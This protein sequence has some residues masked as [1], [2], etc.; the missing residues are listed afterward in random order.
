MARYKSLFER[1]HEELDPHARV[2]N[3]RNRQR[4][5]RMIIHRFVQAVLMVL[6]VIALFGLGKGFLHWLITDSAS[7]Q[8]TEQEA[9]R[10]KW[11]F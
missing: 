11:N 7:T 2:N 10:E 5:R 9:I 8:E 4:H 1:I 3:A 6:M